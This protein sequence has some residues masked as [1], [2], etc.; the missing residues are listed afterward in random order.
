MK[1]TE[2]TGVVRLLWPGLLLLN[3]I[4][5]SC[6]ASSNPCDALS[7]SRSVRSTALTGG[8]PSIIAPTDAQW[9]SPYVVTL[10]NRP[11]VDMARL[12][13]CGGNGRLQIGKLPS[14]FRPNRFLGSRISVVV[15]LLA[16]TQT[17]HPS[18][19]GA[20]SYCIYVETIRSTPRPL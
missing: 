14:H 20:Q 13:W 17:N 1:S 2:P 5:I 9:L 10:N 4:C 11:N 15:C 12:L 19:F 6:G 18:A 7:L 3:C 16:S 8:Q